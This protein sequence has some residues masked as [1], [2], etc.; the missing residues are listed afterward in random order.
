MLTRRHFRL[1]TFGRLSLT[2]VVGDNATVEDVRPRHLAVLAVLAFSSR[3]LPREKLVEMFWGGETPERARH[4]LSNALS[5]LRTV[6]G[7]DAITAR[8]DSVGLEGFPLEVDAVQFV[9]ACEVHDDER[10]AKLYT[11]PFLDGVH[12]PDAENFDRWV[13]RERARFERQFLEVC[14]RQAP[15][16]LRASRWDEAADL[17][18]R[19]LDAAPESAAAFLTLLRAESGPGTAAAL[20]S[21]LDEYERARSL[22]FRSHGI[23]PDASVR[24][25]VA[26]LREW[27]PAAELQLSETVASQSSPPSPRPA[28][29]PPVASPPG[30][31]SPVPEPWL[32]TRLS[33]RRA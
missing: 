27:L 18:R 24:S 29:S 20:R 14:E 2:S 11:G 6:L 26:E 5:A 28:V 22:L 9:S 17:A 33:S 1:Q 23:R 7:P 4:S 32:R 12:V 19:W 31:S 8:Q 16:L 25:L 10:A 30:V 21:A 3:P 15:A 13:G